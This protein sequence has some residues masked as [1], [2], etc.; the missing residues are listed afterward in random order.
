MH[1][2]MYTCSDVKFQ[3]LFRDECQPES[4]LVGRDGLL[5]SPRAACCVSLSHADL[6]LRTKRLML[7]N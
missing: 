2:L 7:T 3:P 4:V 1:V 5:L 6:I